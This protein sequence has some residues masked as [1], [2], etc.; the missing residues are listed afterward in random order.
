MKLKVSTAPHVHSKNSVERIMLDVIIA[1]L[2]TAAVGVYLFG[3]MAGLHII[4]GVASAVLAE[5]ALWKSKAE[6]ILHLHAR[7]NVQKG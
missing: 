7:R 3:Y 6:K 4:V 2:P 5:Y 1:L